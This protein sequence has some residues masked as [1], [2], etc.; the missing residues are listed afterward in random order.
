MEIPITDI[1]TG[2]ISG[3]KTEEEKLH[4]EAHL[5]FSKTNFGMNLQWLFE[6]GHTY[7][8]G[9]LAITFFINF[10][11]W[12]SLSIFIFLIFCILYEESWCNE[13][14]KEK[15]KK[16]DIKRSVNTN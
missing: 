14:A 1:K 9:S 6:T 13:K 12:I 16:K 11:K 4:E 8:L 2:I 5:E 7:L 10:F 3:C 15:L